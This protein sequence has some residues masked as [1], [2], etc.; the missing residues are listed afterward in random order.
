MNSCSY[1]AQHNALLATGQVCCDREVSVATESLPHLSSAQSCACYA[2]SRV[3][4]ERSTLMGVQHRRW[5]AHSC[6]YPGLLCVRLVLCRLCDEC[7]THLCFEFI[8]HAILRILYPY[9][10]KTHKI[11]SKLGFVGLLMKSK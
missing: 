3:L 2:L 9:S 4:W 8:S 7:K 11:S 1:S 10:C 5:C 6:M